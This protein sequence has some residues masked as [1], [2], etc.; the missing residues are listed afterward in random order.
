MNE[1]QVKNLLAA[2]TAQT[3]AMN[4]LAESNEALVAL[5]YQSLADD[6]ETTTLDSPVPTYLSGKP[7]G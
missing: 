1:Q 3:N 2:M 5:L 7:R 6:I 4:R